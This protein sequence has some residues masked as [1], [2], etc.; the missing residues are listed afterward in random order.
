MIYVPTAVNLGTIITVD[1][2][3]ADHF[4]RIDR[5]YLHLKYFFLNQTYTVPFENCTCN[6]FLRLVFKSSIF[7]RR[8]GCLRRQQ[9]L[10]FQKFAQGRMK[11][12]CFLWA[13]R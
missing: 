11:S 8:V 5:R 12:P 2:L 7:T 3:G 13:T 9:H 1:I 10:I 4:R 6:Y